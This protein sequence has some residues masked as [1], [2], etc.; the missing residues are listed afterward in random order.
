MLAKRAMDGYVVMMT[1]VEKDKDG[2][3]IAKVLVKERLAACVQVLGPMTSTYRWKGKVNV[4]SEHL[5]LVKTRQGLCEEVADAIRRTH[6]YEVP[7]IIALPMLGGSSDYLVW[8]SKE[9]RWQ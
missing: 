8:I 4:S 2:E 6:P 9:T 5:L 3:K 7:E 1:T